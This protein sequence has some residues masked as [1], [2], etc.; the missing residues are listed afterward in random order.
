MKDLT[1]LNPYRIDIFG[2][3]LSDPQNGAF[4]IKLPHSILTFKVIASNGHGWEH[5]SVSTPERI[6]KWAEMQA[7][8]EMFFEDHEVVMQLHPRKEDYVNMHPH[9]LHMWRPIGVEIPTPPSW[10]VGLK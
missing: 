7:I 3:G 6:P 4:R 10:M 2:D 1:Y 9:C 8:K 5:V